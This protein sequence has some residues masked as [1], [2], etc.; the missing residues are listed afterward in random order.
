MPFAH[1]VEA[2]RLS[3]H[4]RALA[5]GN[6]AAASCSD[7]HSSHAILPGRD[8]R[9]KTN[10][11]NIP[12]TC[13][14]CHSELA[15]VYGQSVHGQAAAQGAPDAPVCTDC[16]GEHAILAPADPQSPVN[17]GRVSVLTCGRCHGD[18][19]IEARYNLPADRVPTFASS[20][21][22]LASRSGSQTVA[23]CASCHGVYN[24]FPSAD[25]RSTVKPANLAHTCGAC[26]P[27]AG[28]TFAIG[29]IHLGASAQNESGAVKWIRRAYWVLIPAT[30]LFM[31]FH[32]GV[33][34][35][36]KLKVKWRSGSA[37]PLDRMNLDFRIA[38]RMIVVSFPLLVITGF[39]LKFPDSWWARPLLAG[40]GH[41]ALRGTLHRTAAL[42]LL[43]SVVYHI[44]HLILVR[45]DRCVVATLRPHFSDL[46]RIWHVILYN[47][48]F[49]VVRPGPFSRAYLRPEDRVLGSR[50]GNLRDDCH[51]IHALVQ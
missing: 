22:G 20:F 25:P 6:Q 29:P 10:H 4:G 2:Y 41:F 9:S 31:L 44:I 48:G 40:E 17:P 43:A 16:H 32:H 3:V 34:F 51:G 11:W 14:A 18:E 26:H 30:I 7:C 39:A 27:G 24:I 38:H 42:I 28:E 15:S 1:P 36:Q 46:Q 12:K 21:H 45:R 37:R 8:P 49:E 50:L 13:G 5:S 23:N 35:L 33:D 47:L 19:R